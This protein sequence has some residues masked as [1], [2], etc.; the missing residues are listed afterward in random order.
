MKQ[1]L[2]ALSSIASICLSFNSCKKDSDCIP[3]RSCE[4]TGQQFYDKQMRIH[5]C[6]NTYWSIDTV[7]SVDSLYCTIVKFNK[8]NYQRVDSIILT[9]LF[10]SQKIS[11]CIV[12]LYS[13]TDKK[14]LAYNIIE[15]QSPI[16]GQKARKYS[17]DIYKF[18]PDK[19]IN[20]GFRVRTNIQGE[21]AVATDMEL[22]L[23]RK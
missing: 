6:D 4:P 10:Y 20:L 11:K 23:Y 13:L 7:G 16:N 9:G 1:F 21:S 14:V 8:N 2:I 15:Y 17:N 12:D 3:C 18:L 5:I 19:E 22:L